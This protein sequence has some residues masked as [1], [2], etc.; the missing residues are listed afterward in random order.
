MTAERF[1]ALARMA[2]N[3]MWVRHYMHS[4]P[5]YFVLEIVDLLGEFVGERF[6]ALCAEMISAGL[7]PAPEDSVGDV[8]LLRFRVAKEADA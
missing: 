1:L 6:E 5:G 8:K 7:H 3:S 2:S 4:F